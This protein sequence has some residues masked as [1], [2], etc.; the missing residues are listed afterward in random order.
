MGRTIGT[1]REL[2]NV[3]RSAVGV[4]AREHPWMPEMEHEFIK[5]LRN[6]EGFF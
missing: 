6:R 3:K 5:V 2:K 1:N 4:T